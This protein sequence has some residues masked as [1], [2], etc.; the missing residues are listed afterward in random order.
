MNTVTYTFYVENNAQVELGLTPTIST[1]LNIVDNT[2]VSPLP[3]IS[4]IGAGFYKFDFIWDATTSSV[5]YVLKID[6]GDLATNNEA[7]RYITMRIE[8]TDYIA[9]IAAGIKTAAD[10][11][12]QSASTLVNNSN[13]ILDIESGT[14]KI[15]GTELVLYSAGHSKTLDTEI[16]RYDLKDQNGNPTAVSPFERCLTYSAPFT[17]P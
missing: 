11:I 8:P 17:T 6:T 1:M 4:E 7:T 13:R 3:T 10:S 14:W 2:Q 9:N 15:E 12:E 16:A 5:G